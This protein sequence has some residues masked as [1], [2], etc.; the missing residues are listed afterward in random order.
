MAKHTT[1]IIDD[2]DSI[3]VVTRYVAKSTQPEFVNEFSTLHGAAGIIAEWQRAV[4]EAN[5]RGKQLPRESYTVTVAGRQWQVAPDAEGG[6]SLTDDNGYVLEFEDDAD[7]VGSYIDASLLIDELRQGGEMRGFRNCTFAKQ[8]APAKSTHGIDVAKAVMGIDV[9]TGVGVVMSHCNS[10]SGEQDAPAK[11][12]DV[13][14]GS[15]DE[16]TRGTDE[17]PAAGGDTDVE[18]GDRPAE[19]TDARKIWDYCKSDHEIDYFSRGYLVRFVDL[20]YEA[21]DA[22]VS[23]SEFMRMTPSGSVILVDPA[24]TEPKSADRPPEGTDARRIWE[25]IVESQKPLSIIEVGG[26]LGLSL[27]DIEAEVKST[28][29]LQMTTKG[30]I[31]ASQLVIDEET[32]E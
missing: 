8:D 11:T 32:D 18:D 21:I 25:M 15:S 26:F 29:S 17:E 2:G 14:E 1:V 19:G 27:A 24:S 4:F 5:E 20:T 12:A 3:E 31:D 10:E 6:T 30:I 23:T 13:T 9:A 16:P 28:P 7:F 22:A